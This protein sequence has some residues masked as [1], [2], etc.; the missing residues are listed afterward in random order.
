MRFRLG[1]GAI[2]AIVLVGLVGAP[3]LPVMIGATAAYAWLLWK[4][5]ATR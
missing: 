2:A 5:V 3:V 4:A 1:A